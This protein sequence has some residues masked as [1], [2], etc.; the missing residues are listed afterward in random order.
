M[1]SD[2]LPLVLKWTK[3]LRASIF[4]LI[5]GGAAAPEPFLSNF[6]Q[7]LVSFRFLA[8]ALDLDVMP[9]VRAINEVEKRAIQPDGLFQATIIKVAV[10][11]IMTDSKTIGSTLPSLRNGEVASEKVYLEALVSIASHCLKIAHSIGLPVAPFAVI[12]RD[13]MSKLEAHEAAFYAQQVEEEEAQGAL[14]QP[15]P[16]ERQAGTR[17]ARAVRQAIEIIPANPE[18]GAAILDKLITALEG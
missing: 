17:I 12:Q 13:L 14:E 16:L 2:K 1:L 8:K 5:Q 15:E 6:Q 4:T 10:R 9:F 7:V 11:D 18:Y 3:E